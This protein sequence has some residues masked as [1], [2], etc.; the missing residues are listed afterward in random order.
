MTS[1]ALMMTT[2]GSPTFRPNRSIEC[3]VIAADN[4]WPL[5]MSTDT[6][7]ITAPRSMWVIVPMSWL[8]ALNSI[9]IAS[10]HRLD[11]PGGRL[12]AAVA[13]PRQSLNS[14]G[15]RIVAGDPGGG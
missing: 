8:R 9:V 13:D 15:L 4:V 11:R 14:D 7:A 3:L 6:S 2:T 12:Y 1:V 5:P 10:S